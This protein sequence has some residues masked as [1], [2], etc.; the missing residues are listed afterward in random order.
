MSREYTVLKIHDRTWLV[1]TDKLTDRARC[2]FD[3]IRRAEHGDRIELA[4]ESLRD[5]LALIHLPERIELPWP[6]IYFP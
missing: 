2:T 5:L 3:N 6:F 4:P 1:P